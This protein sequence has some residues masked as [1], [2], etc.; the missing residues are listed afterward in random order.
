M[1]EVVLAAALGARAFGNMSNVS[2]PSND[3][4]FSPS[5]QSRAVGSALTVLLGSQGP[6]ASAYHLSPSSDLNG[7]FGSEEASDPVDFNG[8]LDDDDDD[9]PIG[10]ADFNRLTM[11]A[12]QGKVATADALTSEACHA[13]ANFECNCEKS[14]GIRSN[15]NKSTIYAF[16]Y[17]ILSKSLHPR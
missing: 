5:S 13:A 8:D 7:D 16:R 6:S 12:Y 4:A 10:D 17:I 14:C 3:Y 15:C 2:F 11:T 1:K 9:A